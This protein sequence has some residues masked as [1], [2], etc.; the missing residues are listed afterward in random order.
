M[1]TK[2]QKYLRTKNGL[3]RN[4]YSNQRKR[5]KRRNHPMPTYTVDEFI[6]AITDM[7]LFHT[8]FSA[9][10]KS[11][12]KKDLVP[13]IDRL[14]DYLPY[15]EDNIQLTT[16]KENNK[17]HYEDRKAGINNK[18]C[19][20]VVQLDTKGNVVATYYS[21]KNAVDITKIS[22]YGIFDCLRGKQKTAGK[23]L[24]KYKENE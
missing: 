3:L 14:D 9:W 2:N 18:L 17:K 21:I 8:L 12:Y 19:K 4:M 10:E 22:K 16:W 20:P 5:S 23:H 13:S 1:L 11:G 15:T 24:W 7:P 6:E